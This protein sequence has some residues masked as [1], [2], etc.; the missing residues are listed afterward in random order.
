MISYVMS[1]YLIGLSVQDVLKKQLSLWI[2]ILGGIGSAVYGVLCMGLPK[3]AVAMIPGVILIGLSLLMP[4]SIGIGDGMLS[5]IYG[6]VFGWRRT[7]IWLM[8][9][10][11]L[12]AV[13]G[14]LSCFFRKEKHVAIP[15]VPFLAAVHVGMCL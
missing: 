11:L 1:G 12:A 13:F 9:G 10:F 8:L 3:A 4:R 6:L 2:L 14:V 7:C 15:F 5:V